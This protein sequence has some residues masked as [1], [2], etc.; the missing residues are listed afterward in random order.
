MGTGYLNLR[1]IRWGSNP[2]KKSILWITNQMNFRRQGDWAGDDP[3]TINSSNGFSHYLIFTDKTI[4]NIKNYGYLECKTLAQLVGKLKGT[5]V[6]I[7]PDAL[8]LIDSQDKN[9]KDRSKDETPENRDKNRRE[10]SGQDLKEMGLTREEFDL[11]NTAFTDPAHIANLIKK[12]ASQ[13]KPEKMAK[14]LNRMF[15]HLNPKTAEAMFNQMVDKNPV[16][17]AEEKSKLKETYQKAPTKEAKKKVWETLTS[18]QAQ[19]EAH[20]KKTKEQKDKIFEDQVNQNPRYGPPGED[21]QERRNR[22]KEYENADETKKETM[23]AKENERFTQGEN[24]N[25]WGNYFQDNVNHEAGAG[26]ESVGTE[27]DN[28]FDGSFSFKDSLEA[29]NKL[30]NL[31]QMKPEGMEAGMKSNKPYWEV[32]F[33]HPLTYIF[34]FIGLLVAIMAATVKKNKS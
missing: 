12:L 19:R 7:G 5:L 21:T 11:L 14:M 6:R 23:Q 34:L 3:N 26:D 9:Q 16:F 18:H 25:Q 20:Q 17:S 13:E 8:E 15:D 32:I 27:T 28:N 24:A 22:F 10:V 29:I 30:K 33:A 2:H 1:T 31:G 4:S